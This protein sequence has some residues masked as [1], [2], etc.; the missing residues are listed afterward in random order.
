M[1][2]QTMFNK[3]PFSITPQLLSNSAKEKFSGCVRTGLLQIQ[4]LNLVNMFTPTKMKRA[5]Y[6]RCQ[7]DLQ[8]SAP[9]EFSVNEN[10]C[11]NRLKMLNATV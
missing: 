7:W 6:P 10:F 1:F 4:N 9:L 2:L 3:T 5:P 8:H 11:F